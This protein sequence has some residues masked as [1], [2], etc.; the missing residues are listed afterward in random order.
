MDLDNLNRLWEWFRNDMPAD[1]PCGENPARWRSRME[2]AFDRLD[3]ILGADVDE[4]FE[5]GRASGYAE[6][7][8]DERCSIRRELE[9]AIARHDDGEDTVKDL[10][11]SLV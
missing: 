8:M 10:L 11:E 4:I 2:E 3:Y 7:R 9:A 5:D 1:D 6:G